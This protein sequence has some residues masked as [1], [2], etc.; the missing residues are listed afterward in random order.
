MKDKITWCYTKRG[1]KVKVLPYTTSDGK[2][3]RSIQVL[4]SS[5][6]GR[7]VGHR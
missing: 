3:I 5:K 4:K 6:I 7:G 2:K 1:E